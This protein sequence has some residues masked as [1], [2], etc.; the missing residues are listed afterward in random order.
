MNRFENFIIRVSNMFESYARDIVE[1]YRQ[2]FT[3]ADQHNRN[4]IHYGA[5]SKYT[6]CYKTLMS[7]LTYDISEVLVPNFDFQHL[8][9]T[10]QDL[11]TKDE[12]KFDP[13]KYRTVLDEFKHLLAPQ[14]Y[15]RII[16]DFKRSV[17]EL[18]RDIL[19]Q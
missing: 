14:D 17:K 8:F 5:M 10:V 9:M 4:P 6:K 16:F 11:D 15:R 19:N 13:R 3:L 1:K 2:I 18:L 12:A 7:A